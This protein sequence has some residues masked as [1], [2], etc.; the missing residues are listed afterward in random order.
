M[1]NNEE[2]RTTFLENWP[3]SYCIDEYEMCY[4]WMQ[5]IYHVVIDLGQMFK[6][7]IIRA[8]ISSCG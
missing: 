7:S 6:K 3:I 8:T 2:L 1:F 4:L 5:I